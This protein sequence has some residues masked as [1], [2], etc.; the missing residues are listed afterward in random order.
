MA[1]ENQFE[2]CFSKNGS[3]IFMTSE[4]QFECYRTVSALT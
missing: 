3:I 2:L 1:S 4:N